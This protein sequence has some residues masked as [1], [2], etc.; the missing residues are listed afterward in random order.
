VVGFG[1]A[2]ND[3]AFLRLCECSVAVANALESIKQ[4]ADLITHGA[5]GHGVIEVTERLVAD[6][7][8]E[9][10]STVSRHNILLGTTNTGGRVTFPPFDTSVLIAGSSGGGK[11]TATLGIL[12]RLA[13]SGY[14]YC[15]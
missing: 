15:L 7:L 6:D 14:Q 4:R 3:Y 9:Y 2:E 10:M 8:R 1:D 13:E 5:H 12:E 11:S